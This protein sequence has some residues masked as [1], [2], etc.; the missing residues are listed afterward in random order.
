M[1]LVDNEANYDPFPSAMH[2][3]LFMLINSP[4]P[5]VCYIKYYYISYNMLY[6]G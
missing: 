3:L 1:E 6:L 2:A 4:R 5:I